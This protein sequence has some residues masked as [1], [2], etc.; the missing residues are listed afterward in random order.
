MRVQSFQT[1]TTSPCSFFSLTLWTSIDSYTKGNDPISL[2]L[3]PQSTPHLQIDFDK[4]QI[5]SFTVLTEE[6]PTQRKDLT[7][8][9]STSASKSPHFQPSDW[10]SSMRKIALFSF[11]PRNTRC[12]HKAHLTQLYSIQTLRHKDCTSILHSK[13]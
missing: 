3:A 7:R 8:D 5:H 10:R 13:T 9:I 2:S 12:M 4:D 11:L 1:T 6:A